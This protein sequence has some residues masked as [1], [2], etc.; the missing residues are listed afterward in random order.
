MVDVD[1]RGHREL[2]SRVAEPAVWGR[3]RI[4]VVARVL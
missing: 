3:A 1:L 2:N 4:G